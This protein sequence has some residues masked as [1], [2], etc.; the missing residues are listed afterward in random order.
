MDVICGYNV[1][2]SEE[3]NNDA[4]KEG[5]E[6]DLQSGGGIG[7]LVRHLAEFVQGPM[8]MYCVFN[9]PQARA[10]VIDILRMLVVGAPVILLPIATV[11]QI[12]EVLF[13]FIDAN[14][15]KGAS[16]GASALD[17]SSCSSNDAAHAL[18][19]LVAIANRD[20]SY[21]QILTGVAPLIETAVG[22][23]VNTFDGEHKLET[24]GMLCRLPEVFSNRFPDFFSRACVLL[25]GC[26]SRHRECWFPPSHH[27]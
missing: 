5:K 17:Q 1:K 16:S 10:S 24:L 6:G 9:R 23:T 13:D 7:A 18:N 4:D 26:D 3:G 11:S 20:Q 12:M 25:E 27:L 2:T 14:R 21:T 15:K 19:A 22:S 8:V